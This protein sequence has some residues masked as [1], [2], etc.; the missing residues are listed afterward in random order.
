MSI[1]RVS[2]NKDNPYVMIDK[3][4]ISDERLSWKAKGVLAYLLSLP[5]NWEIYVT[6]IEKHSTDGEKSLR[7]GL[8]ELEDAGYLEKEIIRDSTGKFSGSAYVVYERPTVSP[9]AECRKTERRKPTTTNNDLNNNKLTNK[10]LINDTHKEVVTALM[11]V[12]GLDINI[13]TNA[14]RLQRASKEL[15]EAGYGVA[16][17]LAFGES[18]KHDWRFK[19]DK[20][21]PLISVLV[22]EIGRHKRVDVDVE[23]RKRKAIEQM[24]KANGI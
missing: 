19:Q 24:E 18:W 13:K 9:K 8:K 11:K 7:S 22:S 12:T 6:E 2:K 23:E 17:I 16:E 5:D 3:T 20:K 1:I 15:R 4:A 14:G 10:V 21:P